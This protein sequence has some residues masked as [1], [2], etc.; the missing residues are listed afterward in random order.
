MN[1]NKKIYIASKI[2]K[3][4]YDYLQNMILNKEIPSMYFLINKLIENFV[5]HRKKNEKNEKNE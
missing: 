3:E 5:N 2:N 4:N 1:K